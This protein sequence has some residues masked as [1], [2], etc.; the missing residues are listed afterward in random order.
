MK[1]THNGRVH[2]VDTEADIRRLTDP[3]PAD[4]TGRWYAGRFYVAGIGADQTTGAPLA[5]L[6]ARG[7]RYAVDL[8]E[9]QALIDSGLMQE[10][11]WLPAPALPA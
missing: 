3:A 5:V 1:V 7:E 2:D 8:S 6:Y 4:P 9:L 11:P 10:E